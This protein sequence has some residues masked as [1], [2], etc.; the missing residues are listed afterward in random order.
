MPDRRPTL[1]ELAAQAASSGGLACPKCACRH[2]IRYGGQD[3]SASVQRYRRCRNCGFR[4]ITEERVVRDVDAR[5]SEDEVV[6]P[7]LA[8]FPDAGIP[9]LNVQFKN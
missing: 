7:V 6:E 9:R 5:E 2:L 8:T 4:I 3:R 1:A